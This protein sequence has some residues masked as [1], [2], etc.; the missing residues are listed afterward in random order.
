MNRFGSYVDPDV[1]IMTLEKRPVK[2]VG[3]IVTGERV[4]EAREV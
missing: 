1:E 2:A 4:G 3:A